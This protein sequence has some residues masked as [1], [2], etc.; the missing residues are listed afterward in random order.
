MDEDYKNI[1]RKAHYQYMEQ[2]KGIWEQ[3]ELFC[4]L[5]GSSSDAITYYENSFK[6][7][8]NAHLSASLREQP[9]PEEYF[10]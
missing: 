9:N 5:S 1:V 10:N 4:N 8:L 6:D 3:V 7:Y 2:T